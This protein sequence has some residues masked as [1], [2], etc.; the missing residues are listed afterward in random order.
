M[1]SEKTGRAGA[2]RAGK[3]IAAK[4]SGGKC[5]AVFTSRGYH[6]ASGQ[7]RG[8]FVILEASGGSASLS[9]LGGCLCPDTF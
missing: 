3:S 2:L 1:T 7:G 9:D 4:S 8:L 5:R 6:A